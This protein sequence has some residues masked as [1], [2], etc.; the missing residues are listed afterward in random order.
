MNALKCLFLGLKE[1]RYVVRENSPVGMDCI[2]E[3]EN[4]TRVIWKY[5]S[6]HDNTTETIYDSQSNKSLRT[7]FE[8]SC[9]PHQTFTPMC[10]LTLVQARKED[11]GKYICYVGQGN[12]AK[13]DSH[14]LKPIIEIEL[15]I[16]GII[17]KY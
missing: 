8:I 16:K 3:Q 7:G 13:F 5:Q 15:V 14:L 17:Y 1:D 9:K 12:Y 6:T 10:T 4:V 11:S 2:H